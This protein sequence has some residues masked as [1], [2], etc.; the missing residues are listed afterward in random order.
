MSFI[1]IKKMGVTGA[2]AA[3]LC[4]GAATAQEAQQSDNDA[5]A[6]AALSSILGTKVE[7][8]PTPEVVQNK[9]LGQLQTVIDRAYASPLSNDYIRQLEAEIGALDPNQD[10]VDL[11]RLNDRLEALVKA[12]TVE[13]TAS[14]IALIDAEAE[15]AQPAQVEPKPRD[16]PAAVQAS[17]EIVSISVVDALMADRPDEVI[18]QRGDTLTGIANKYYGDASLF[19]MIAAA[20]NLA[21]PSQLN[22]GQRLILP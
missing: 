15:G 2:F 8:E 13:G 5:M 11:S 18:V 1:S 7:P 14:Y 17:E 22:V 10:T 19:P 12:A 20:N 16:L 6:K 21:N 9:S 4:A 3:A